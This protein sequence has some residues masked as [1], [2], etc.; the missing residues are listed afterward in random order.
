MRNTDEIYE[1]KLA[2]QCQGVAKCLTYN[3]DEH[4]AAAQGQK[5]VQRLRETLAG[6]LAIVDDSRGVAGYHLNGAIAD[7]DEFPEVESARAM[8][9]A[10]PKE[11]THD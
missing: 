2:S 10:A 6:L 9:A 8:L 11:S 1:S 3:D 4:Q 5:E 7:W